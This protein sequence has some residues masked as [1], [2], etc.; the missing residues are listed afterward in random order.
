MEAQRDPDFRNILRDAFLVT[1]DGMP[2]VWMGRLQGHSQIDRVY[3]PDLMLEVCERSTPSGIR[4][5]FYGGKP[6]V[7]DDLAANL[8]SMFPK[9]VIAGTFTPPFRSLEP[10][11]LALL[12]QKM[13]DARPDIVW[14]GLSTPKQEKFMASY[15]KKLPC[16]I[17][18][19]VGAAFDIHAGRTNDAPDWIKNIGMQWAH[20]LFQEP[21]RLWKRYL[22]NNFAFL[23]ALGQQLVGIRR[24]SLPTSETNFTP[25]E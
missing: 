10:P 3:G 24:Y 4:H 6:G 7:A 19:G 11:E 8:Q 21:T 13:E 23:A 14:V 17:M 15:I 18:I 25:S 12:T 1:P 9:M 20:R 16:K 2:T 22:V 5:F